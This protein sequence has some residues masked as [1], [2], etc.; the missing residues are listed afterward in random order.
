MRTEEASVTES[1]AV[2]AR[3][4]RTAEAAWL[5]GGSA[6][7]ML[8]GLSLPRP[9]SDLD[10]YADEPDAARLHRVLA[11]YAIDHPEQSRTELYDSVL[12]HYRMGSLQIELVGGFTITHASG[13]YHT[14]TRE[15]LL[16]EAEY[17]QV[18]GGRI[19]LVPLVHELL[20]NALRG[21]DDR[22]ALI[23]AAIAASSDRERH[24]RLLR[25]IIARN[26]L[27]P[28]LT[29]R[30]TRWVAGESQDGQR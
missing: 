13:I 26:R 23:A 8:R 17:E 19:A 15:V 14:E 6:G 22:T 30:M 29:Q 12:S 1:L 5:V 11:P 24:E 3:L 21:R 2:I 10:L 27:S 18:D 16:P 28:E 9:P 20:F 7:L 25:T 4:A